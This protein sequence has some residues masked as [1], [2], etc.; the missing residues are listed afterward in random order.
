MPQGGSP[1][2]AGSPAVASRRT[3]LA[4]LAALLAGGGGRIA[5]MA[6]NVPAVFGHYT[7]YSQIAYGTDPQHRLDVYVPE[8]V[9][10][11]RRPTV[12]FWH[13]GR[14]SSGDKADY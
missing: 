13:G 3:A 1:M 4:G 6:A 14:W 8:E 9:P 11:E 5:F 10:R 2:S 12:V 7:R